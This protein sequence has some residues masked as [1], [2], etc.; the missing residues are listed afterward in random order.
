MLCSESLF[1]VINEMLTQLAKRKLDA[2][3]SETSEAQFKLEFTPSTTAELANF[4]TFLDDIQKRVRSSCLAVSV[5]SFCSPL[6]STV[7]YTTPYSP[8]FFLSLSPDHSA[9][10]GAGDNMSDV[11]FDQQILSSHTPRGCCGFRHLA[12]FY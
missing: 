3:I 5:T 2:V 1:Q 10:G 7:F 8:S 9:R 12:T 4:L 6:L 11:Q